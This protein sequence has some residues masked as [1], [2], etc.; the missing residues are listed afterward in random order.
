MKK[1]I[2]DLLNKFSDNK[3]LSD[4]EINLINVIEIS[5]KCQSIKRTMNEII[6]QYNIIKNEMI[7]KLKPK[8][9]RR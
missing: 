3:P 1:S 7:S 9:K 6:K 5:T 2:K 4:K 8:K